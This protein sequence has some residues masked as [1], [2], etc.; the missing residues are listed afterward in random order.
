VEHF[1][2]NPT[3]TRR[4]KTKIGEDKDCTAFA[5]FEPIISKSNSPPR[6]SY[7][8]GLGS[9]VYEILL[10]LAIL[11]VCLLA[12]MLLLGKGSAPS[13]PRKSTFMTT[14][15]VLLVAFAVLIPGLAMAGGV[16]YTTSGTFSNPNLFPI[17]FIGTSVTN[18][19]G[20]N[21]SFGQF[22]VGRWS[23]DDCHHPGN[24]CRGSETFTLKITETSPVSATVDLVG[25]IFGHV[26]NG[27]SDLTLMFRTATVTIGST[28]YTVQFMHRIKLG[29]RFLNGNVDP[30]P[31]PEPSAAFL[32]GIGALGLMGLATVSRKIIST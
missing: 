21:L 1:Q 14:R 27:H 4:T 15:I 22:D 20:G 16:S 31:V 23:L 25:K 28:V 24:S 10:R 17:T 13:Q 7:S 12:I 5:D 32:L 6:S 19:E 2:A 3:Q 26:R 8:T 11:D 30:T 29:M 9:I 18:F